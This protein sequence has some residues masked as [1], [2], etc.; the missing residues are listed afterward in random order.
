MI[1]QVEK[2]TETKQEGDNTEQSSWNMIK[3]YS[4][5]HFYS[6]GMSYRLCGGYRHMPIFYGY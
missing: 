6:G 4:M 2:L 1:E 5:T 3:P